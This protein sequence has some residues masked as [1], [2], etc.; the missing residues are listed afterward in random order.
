MVIPS[1][2][3]QPIEDDAS[4]GIHVFECMRDM[5]TS[6]PAD[7]MKDIAITYLKR[8]L[9]CHYPE[10]QNYQRVL[11]QRREITFTKDKGPEYASL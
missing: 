11:Q 4:D 9:A 7:E 2:E 5:A 8:L 3:L 6:L 10:E 1:A